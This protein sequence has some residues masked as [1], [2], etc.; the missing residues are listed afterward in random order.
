MMLDLL[1]CFCKTHPELSYKQVLWLLLFPVMRWFLEWLLVSVL[2]HQWIEGWGESKNIQTIRLAFLLTLLWR[3]L[4]M[5]WCL[6]SHISYLCTLP[7]SWPPPPPSQERC[8]FSIIV[9]LKIFNAPKSLFTKHYG[10]L[11]LRSLDF[12]PFHP[13]GILQLLVCL[14]YMSASRI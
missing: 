8:P 4:W 2:H 1:F 7:L 9:K 12:F 5:G 3:G 6:Q 13:W 10:I 14:L 11:S